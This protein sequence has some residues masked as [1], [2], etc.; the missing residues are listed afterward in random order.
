[1]RIS[2]AYLL[3]YDFLKLDEVTYMPANRQK[4]I[5]R[6]LSVFANIKGTSKLTKVNKACKLAV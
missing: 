3:Y 5:L 1:M 6:T 2:I 4:I